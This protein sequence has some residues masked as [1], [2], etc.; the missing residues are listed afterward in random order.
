MPLVGGDLAR[1]AVHGELVRIVPD[2]LD[3]LGV[4][5]PD[6]AHPPLLSA[7]IPQLVLVLVHLQ[8][9]GA[10]GLAHGEVD[11]GE[12][13]L[14]AVAEVDPDAPLEDCPR[15][16]QPGLHPVLAGAAQLAAFRVAPE[17]L[18]QVRGQVTAVA[19]QVAAV[20]SVIQM[21]DAHVLLQRP[22]GAKGLVTLLTPEGLLLEVDAADVPLQLAGV[23][24]GLR[25]VFA[26][27]GHGGCFGHLRRAAAR[28]RRC[29]NR[30]AAL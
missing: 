23:A 19:A 29:S 27:M 22:L 2:E 18:P 16:L 3:R 1:L 17:V 26:R 28:R 9:A 4:G 10:P 13:R 24:K 14:L 20:R 12:E 7:G 6:P 15:L 8:H 30:P 5:L 21:A 11:A 25:T